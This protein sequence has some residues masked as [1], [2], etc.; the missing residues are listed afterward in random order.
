MAYTDIDK[1][2][3]Y[4]NTVL[5]TGDGN[6]NRSVT[7]VGFQP[8]WTWIKRRNTDGY[9]VLFDAVRGPTNWLY[10]NSSESE[11]SASY[12]DNAAFISD[13]FKPDNAGATNASGSTYVGWS[14][15]A[16]NST[17]SNTDG[18]ITSTVSANTTSGFS[19]VSWTNS[20]GSQTIGHGLGT[21]PQVVITKERN[22]SGSWNSYFSAVGNA[23]RMVL[24][25]TNAK[26]STSVW[27]STNPTSTVFSFNDSIS[28]TMIAYCFAEK[29]GFSKFGSYTGNGSSDGPFVYTGFKPAF[30]MTK[31]SSTSGN[32]KTSWAVGHVNG[33][34]RNL[35]PN[36]ISGDNSAN[37]IDIL[38]NGFKCRASDTDR[39]GS[40]RTYI[41]MA[42][43]ENPFVTST[44][45]PG[46]A[47]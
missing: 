12:T 20:S 16:S 47:Q 41:Y 34:G 7:G 23:H 8:D 19:I 9:N 24:Q 31:C 26:I 40:G 15:L 32:W 13:G 28:S 14:W 38:S 3:D 43:A 36:L 27:N 25:G 30:V 35:S 6:S 45:I 29:K 11:D 22:N 5:Y 18:S 46:L 10:S 39:N 33:T 42:I 21:A 1:S 17:A 44:G 4:F 37:K 2:D